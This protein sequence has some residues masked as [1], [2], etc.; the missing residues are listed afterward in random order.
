MISWGLLSAATALVGV[1]V[2]F[3]LMVRPAEAKMAHPPAARLAR[4]RLAW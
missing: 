1:A 3:W 4:R 2:L